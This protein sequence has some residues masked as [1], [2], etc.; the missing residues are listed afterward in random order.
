[1]PVY[2][3]STRI[4]TN[5]APSSVLYDLCIYRMDSARNKYLLVDVKQ[6]TLQGN[7]ETQKHVTAD[8]NESLSTIYI[9]QVTL[10]RKT[11]LHTHRVSAEPFTK[12]YTLQ[13][14]TSGKS[15]SPV[16]RENPCYFE[17]QGA[18]KPESEGGETK[19]LKISTPERPFIAKDYPI[20]SPRDPFE[21]NRIEADIQDRFY[22]RSYPSQVGASVCGP[23]VFFYCLQKDRPD[24]YAQAANELWRYGK[25][26]IG[27]L[28]I[29]PG[30]GCRHPAGHFYDNISGLDWMT[31]AGLRDSE[32][33]IFRFDTLDSPFAGITMWQTLTKWFEKS[34][35]EKIFSNVGV[36]QAGIKGVD[37]LNKYVVQGCKVVTLVNDSLLRDSI[38]EH[39]TYPTHWIV[40][41]GPLTAG[42]DGAV[43]LNLFS[44][45]DESEQLKPNKDLSFF[46]RR[47]FG[48]VVFKPLK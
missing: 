24:V 4:H 13:E 17:S 32:N 27:E 23:A 21:R 34:G 18:M 12:M 33:A 10:Y 29:V 26:K 31:L 41:D 14:F 15:W 6:Q 46:I 39:T 30:D 1:M 47:F 38:S 3:V 37:D 45:G 40:W 5:V 43:T 8:I 36:T 22:H 9:M 48:G 2:Y 16:K 44:W 11:M 19:V 20:G 42:S 35:Y 7:F 25:T 28:D